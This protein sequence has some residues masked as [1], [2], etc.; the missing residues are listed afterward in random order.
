LVDGAP[1]PIKEK[2]NKE[3]ADSIKAKIEEAGGSVEV[4]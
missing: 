3:E 4:K 1:K 2:V